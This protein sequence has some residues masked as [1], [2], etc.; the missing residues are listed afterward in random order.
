MTYQSH[1][2]SREKRGQILSKLP[3]FRGCTIWF[4]G[5]EIELVDGVEGKLF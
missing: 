4:T 1:H 2:V 3:G 5:K